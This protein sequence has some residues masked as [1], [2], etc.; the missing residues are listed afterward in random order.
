MLTYEEF[1]NIARLKRLSLANAEKDY[2]Q[3]IVLF[4]IYSIAGKELVFKGG[5]CLY[6]IYKL[7]RF[8][9]DLDFT[10]AKLDIEKLSSKIVSDLLLLNVKGRIKEIKEYKEGVNVRLLFNG[11]LY[12]GSKETQC[13]IPLNISLRENVLLE[14][15]KE[16]V[17]SLYR[18]IPNF[19]V[20][21]MDEKEILAEKVRTIFARQKPRD[22]YDL[23]FLLEKNIDLDVEMIN[24]KLSLNNITFSK[25]EFK[26][27][28]EKMKG[29][30]QI[31]LKNLMA[32]E[33]DF[34]KVKREIFDKLKKI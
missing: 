18:E 20:F 32:K 6:K 19:E 14:P 3:N 31:D 5:T 7:D 11:P 13:F 26:R 8:S 23:H 17:F 12:R 16:M 29:L 22:I 34:E 33:I 4:S 9:E 10:A 27:R 15:R 21:A 1:E 30:W 24:K 28:I 25:R 2:L